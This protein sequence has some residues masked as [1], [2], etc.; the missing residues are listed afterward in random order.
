[1]LSG[2]LS[3]ELVC[4]ELRDTFSAASLISYSTARNT[5]LS[6]NTIRS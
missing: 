3:E 6:T 4:V 1:M 2:L 5:R